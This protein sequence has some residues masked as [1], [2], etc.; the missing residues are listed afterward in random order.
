MP[1]TSERQNVQKLR[2]VGFSQD[3]AVTFA[4]IIERL[5]QQGFE[6]FSE[7][8]ERSMTDFRQQMDRRF[9]DFDARLELLESRMDTKIEQLRVE[10]H[11]S[12]RTLKVRLVGAV[13][14]IVSLAVAVIKLFPDWR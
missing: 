1:I 13:V 10:L 5:H 11:S 9:A 12:L 2:G 3:Q 6:K 14:A 4:E 7:V 8:L